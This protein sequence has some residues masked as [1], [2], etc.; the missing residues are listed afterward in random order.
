MAGPT[1]AIIAMGE[2]GA[3]LAARLTARG[4]RVRTSLAGRSAAR[5]LAGGP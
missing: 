3:G 2:M 5:S 1:V 4:A